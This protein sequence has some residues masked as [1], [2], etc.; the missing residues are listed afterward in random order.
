MNTWRHALFIL[1]I[2]LLA[3]CGG[4]GD[5]DQPSV[6][7]LSPSDQHSIVLGETVQIESRAKDDHAVN[8][9]ELRI[10]DSMAQSASVPGGEKS[11][12]VVLSWL[13][14]DV[15]I[16][17]VSVVAYDDKEQASQPAT[18]TIA[19]QPA[20]TPTTPI[21]PTATP[22]AVPTLTPTQSQGSVGP[23]GCT[24]N[25]TFVADVTISDNT[26]MAPGTEFVKTWRLR[27][28]GT[29]DWG[30]GFQFIF[31]DGEQMSGPAGVNV[32]PTPAGTTVDISVR[33]K[34]PEKPGTYRGRWRV[35]TPDGRDFGDRPFVQIVV[36]APAT[37]TPP[38][39]PT[40]TPAPKAD[41]DITLVAGNL[42]LL[43]GELLE[44]RVTVR[45]HGPGATER[46]ALVRA[47]LRADLEIE[48]SVATLPAGGQ[49]VV[50]L[51]HTFDA[52]ADLEAF[53]SVDPADEITEENKDNNTER[54]PI[55]VNPPLY[56]TRTI[57]ATPGLRFDLDAGVTETE[58]LDIEWRVVEGTAYLGLLNGAGAAW[59]MG[60]SASVSYALVAGLTWETEQLMLADLTE[61]SLFGFRTEEGRVGYA[62]VTAVLDDARTSVQL[63]Y[64]VWDWP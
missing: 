62:R 42:E 12:R 53:I 3:A 2:I 46:P 25:A 64:A 44:L 26:K 60:E 49:E 22:T 45:N 23:D 31:I 5:D 21:Q 17:N 7:I 13:A 63:T 30:A 59:I 11:F 56:V 10:N 39:T 51:R 35:R 58:K 41:L 61:G 9:V 55:V 16:Y 20:P 32:S 33:L 36:P 24:Y 37:P 28:S 50:V 38:V 48:G 15:G 14:P 52:P 57:T 29:C 1:L 18:I 47:A 4:R 40:T 27:N 8:R 6:K 19:V 34:A 43:V 54:I